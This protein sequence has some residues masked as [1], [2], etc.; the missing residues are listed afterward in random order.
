MR[1]GFAGPKLTLLLLPLVLDWFH[2]K[3]IIIMK[4]RSE[5]EDLHRGSENTQTPSEERKTNE[6]ALL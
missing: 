2:S 6:V 4:A 3:H 1:A 5:R